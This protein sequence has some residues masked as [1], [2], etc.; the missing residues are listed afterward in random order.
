M[1][2]HHASC[3]FTRL[4]LALVLLAL[5]PSCALAQG[6]EAMQKTLDKRLQ[7]LRFD[8]TALSEVIDFLRDISGANITVNWKT[9]EAAGI[10]KTT[11]VSLRLRDI[12]FHKALSTILNEV[13]GSNVK[14]DY[15][16]EDG[17]ITI[18]TMEELNRNT[19]ITVY[20]IR[21][22]IADPT[23]FEHP[24][25]YPISVGSGRP[26]QENHRA[27]VAQPNDK[28]AI[29]DISNLI[30]ETVDRESWVDNGGKTGQI[31]YLSGQLII[32]Q[33]KPNHLVVAGL[34]DKLREMRSIQIAVDMRLIRVPVGLL[35]EAEVRKII[36]PPA[37]A[38]SPNR[39]LKADEVAQLLKTLATDPKSSI[40]TAPRITCFN[41]R[42][43]TVS[44]GE[45]HRYISG[46]RPAGGDF[47]AVT[48]TLTSGINVET[49]ASATPDLSSVTVKLS[50]RI[51]RFNGLKD[52]PWP[53][54]AE[55][56]R[57]MIQEPGLSVS[58]ISSVAS[59]TKDQTVILVVPAEP[60]SDMATLFAVSATAFRANEPRK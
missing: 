48:G 53:N 20:D 44:V 30:K 23:E 37:D 7:E 31:K 17:A 38:K 11:P 25:D 14:L 55:G 16:V 6:D 40:L 24:P 46:Y 52:K 18:S 43:A 58:E 45:E 59:L 12:K 36:D 49:L 29:E 54:A 50:P 42:K 60:G 13:G 51:T 3:S 8:G 5:P 9:I 10:E 41:T 27:P 15:D 34:L 26:P 33:T 22:L 57:L 2:R 56:K 47:D 19:V 1:V 4:F 28:Q 32:T 39:L 35:Q 21:D